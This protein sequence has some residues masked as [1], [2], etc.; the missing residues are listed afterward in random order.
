MQRRIGKAC[1]RVILKRNAE[2]DSLLVLCLQDGNLLLLYLLSES[3]ISK[4]AKL[5]QQGQGKE[6][7]ALNWLREITAIRSGERE[8]VHEEIM[9]LLWCEL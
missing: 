1:Q 5:K 2:D 6:V 3:C 4:Q 9:S 7:W 8:F